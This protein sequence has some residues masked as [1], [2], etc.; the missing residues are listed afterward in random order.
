[1]KIHAKV[2]WWLCIRWVYF[3]KVFFSVAERKVTP[4]CFEAFNN[5]SF[6][7]SKLN[8]SYTRLHGFIMNKLSP[9]FAQKNI[10]LISING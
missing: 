5:P 1:M 10:Q 3:R 2:D 9:I 6:C 7:I 4:V 8:K